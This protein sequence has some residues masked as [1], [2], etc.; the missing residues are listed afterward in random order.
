MKRQEHAKSGGIAAS[1]SK[2]LVDALLRSA[3]D[4]VELIDLDGAIVLTNAE[5]AE[6]ADENGA[7]PLGRP[8]RSLWP[9]E[10]RRQIDWLLANA[11]LGRMSTAT[12][13]R[14]AAKGAPD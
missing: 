10:S 11:K 12:I 13:Y 4:S 2:S 6:A 7:D 5:G 1:S 14:A 9:K 3:R 8:W